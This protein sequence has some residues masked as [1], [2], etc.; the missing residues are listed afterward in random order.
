[1]VKATDSIETPAPNDASYK[2]WLTADVPRKWLGDALRGLKYGPRRKV[3]RV[4]LD[5]R[6]GG[7]C[8]Y[9]DM[10]DGQQTPRWGACPD[11]MLGKRMMF[12]LFPEN[13]QEVKSVVTSEIEGN[14][15]GCLVNLAHELLPE[16]S[17]F[18]EPTGI[19]WAATVKECD[20]F[21]AARDG[22]NE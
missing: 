4:E 21:T 5:P 9:N 18:A 10:R 6:L 19:G 16:E 11:V 13:T 20:E 7:S 17:E 15:K 1:M 14:A 22:G 8:S 12:S 3:V 2:T